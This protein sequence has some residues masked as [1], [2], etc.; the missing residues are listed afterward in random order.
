PRA[1][2]H[3]IS[4]YVAATGRSYVCFDTEKDEL[5]LP[6][7][8]GARSS[9]TVPLRLHD[10]VIGTFDVESQQVAAFGEDDRQFAEIFGRYIAMALHMLDLLVVE[11]SQTNQTVS[12][13]VEDEIK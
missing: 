5:F 2:G 4:G 3:G 6:G 12:G 10:K 7:L 11:R 13:R 1:E 8:A 9:V